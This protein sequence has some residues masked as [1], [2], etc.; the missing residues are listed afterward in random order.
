MIAS[1]V[2]LTKKRDTQKLRVQ[3]KLKSNLGRAKPVKNHK[4]PYLLT[5]ITYCA[6]CGDHMPGKSAHGNSGKIAYYEHSWQTKKNSTLSKKVFDCKPARVPAKIAEELVMEKVKLLIS[7]EQFAKDLFTQAKSQLGQN[8]AE[9]DL[10]R[11]RQRSYGL[12]SQ[13]EA[14]AE[15]IANLPSDVPPEPLY[16]QLAKINDLKKSEEK[17][18]PDLRSMAH[19]KGEVADLYDFKSLQNALKDLINDK[20][21]PEVLR[22]VIARLIHRIEIGPDFIEIKYIVGKSD[23]ALLDQEIPSRLR[24]FGGG[25]GSENFLCKGSHSLTFGA[26]GRT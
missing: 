21:N 3:K 10:D 20:T 14:L 13:I 12:N 22:A 17:R 7:S 19:N 4:M 25:Q 9:K 26:P 23:L 6:T 5:G 16:R 2:W 18:L 8:I 15:R 1:K 11:C 24:E